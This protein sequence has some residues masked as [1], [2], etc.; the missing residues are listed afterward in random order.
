LAVVVHVATVLIIFGG[1]RSA[2]IPRACTTVPSCQTLFL[3]GNRVFFRLNVLCDLYSAGSNRYAGI[4]CRE[5]SASRPAVNCKV[6]CTNRILDCFAGI[7]SCLPRR[8]HALT[9]EARRAVGAS[10]ARVLPECTRIRRRSVE[11]EK[12]I[13]PICPVNRVSAGIPRRPCRRYCVH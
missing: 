7:K 10:A 1:Y 2:G 5:W 4:A 13:E 11:S 9:L 3:R 8:L 12:E 6:P